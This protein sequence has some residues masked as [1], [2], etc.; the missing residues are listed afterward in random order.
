ME[1]PTDNQNINKTL[2]LLALISIFMI[3]FVVYEINNEHIFVWDCQVI[4]R[5]TICNSVRP[6]ALR[7]RN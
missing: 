6:M 4:E 1:Q 3:L 2:L 7:H 5:K